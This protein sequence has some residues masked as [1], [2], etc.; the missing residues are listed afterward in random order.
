MA[1]LVL[2][3]M[4][5]T[6]VAMEQLP[7]SSMEQCKVMATEY[8]ARKPWFIGPEGFQAYCL[9]DKDKIERVNGERYT[10]A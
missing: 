1:W 3:V 10:I 5:S 6:G 8:L 9:N 2:I 4:T 7:A